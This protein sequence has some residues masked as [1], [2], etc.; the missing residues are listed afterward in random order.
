MRFVAPASSSTHVTRTP[1][2]RDWD[3]IVSMG[4]SKSKVAADDVQPAEQV[5]VMSDSKRHCTDC[6]CI[7]VFALFW[8]VMLIIAVLGIAN[9][10]PERCAR[11]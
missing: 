9:G 7:L 8:V 1:D 4:S 10:N 11:G 3:P 6:L 5:G 2:V